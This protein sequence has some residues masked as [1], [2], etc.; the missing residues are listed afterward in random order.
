MKTY[1]LQL[2]PINSFS[3]NN[4]NYLIVILK[5]QISPLIHNNNTNNSSNNLRNNNYNN[6]NNSNTNKIK[7]LLKINNNYNKMI[8]P[9]IIVI[10]NRLKKIYMFKLPKSVERKEKLMNSNKKLR[11]NNI[12][13]T[14]R[15][16]LPIPNLRNPNTKPL[17]LIPKKLITTVIH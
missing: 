17:E 6:N 1:K 12:I 11:K 10:N 9:K 2:T 16:I 14:H 13:I 4:N 15:N 7:Y 5:F 8:V 3:K